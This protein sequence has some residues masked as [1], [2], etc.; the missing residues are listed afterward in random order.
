MVMVDNCC[1]DTAKRLPNISKADCY[2]K[3]LGML[4]EIQNISSSERIRISSREWNR[5]VNSFYL[6]LMN[7]YENKIILSDVNKSTAQ[8]L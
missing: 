4:Y 6:K 3:I 5:T 2:F 7:E 1:Q 8:L